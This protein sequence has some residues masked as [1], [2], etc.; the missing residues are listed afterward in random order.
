MGQ[1]NEIQ[2]NIYFEHDKYLLNP[3]QQ[4]RLDSLIALPNKERYDLHIK[5]FTN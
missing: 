3:E 5:G 2:F 1:D 4:T